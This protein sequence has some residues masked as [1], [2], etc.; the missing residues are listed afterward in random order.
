MKPIDAPDKDMTEESK[1]KDKKPTSVSTSLTHR[2]AVVCLSALLGKDNFGTPSYLSEDGGSVSASMTDEGL[3]LTV[4]PSTF[5]S[6]LARMKMEE[7]R[8]NERKARQHY[9]PLAALAKNGNET[10]KAQAQAAKDAMDAAQSVVDKLESDFPYLKKERIVSESERL[11]SSAANLNAQADKL[12]EGGG[13][14]KELASGP[15]PDDRAVEALNNLDARVFELR[16]QAEEKL[17]E[18]SEVL[19]KADGLPDPPA[20]IRTVLPKGTVVKFTV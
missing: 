14:W 15:E 16:T 2:Q 7:A 10:A 11:K 20:D 5:D 4:S 3:V 12:A 18:A 8:S 13:K 1:A 6:E 17:A 19:F 9:T